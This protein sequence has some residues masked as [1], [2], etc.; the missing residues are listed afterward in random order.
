MSV[1]G[2]WTLHYDWGC[3]GNYSQV[4]MTF[5]NNGTFTLAPYSGKWVQTEGKIIWKFDQAP[6]TVYGGDL[7]DAAMLG[8]SSTFAGLNGCWYALRTGV[9]TAPFA[10]SKPEHDVAGN[11]ASH[12]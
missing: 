1:V 10:E 7:V 11:K 3:T 6:N 9:K 12:K 2:T 4:S 5:N 8:I